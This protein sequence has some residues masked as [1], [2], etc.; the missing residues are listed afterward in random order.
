M[1]ENSTQLIGLFVSAFISATVAP[2]GSEAVL[3]YLV[4]L[5][6]L[7]VVYLVGVATLG[8]TLGAMTTWWLGYLVEKK[9]TTEHV[10]KNKQRALGFFRRMGVWALLFSWVPIIGDALCFVAGWLKLPIVPSCLLIMTGKLARY[11][12]IAWLFV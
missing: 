11:A 5:N 6:T 10:A 3:A 1:L 9:I 7:P 12:A 4:S 8:N 2:G